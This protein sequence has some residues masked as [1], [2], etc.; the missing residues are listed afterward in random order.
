MESAKFRIFIRLI[1][2]FWITLGFLSAF[3]SSTT[4][5]KAHEETVSRLSPQVES[6]DRNELFELAKAYSNL[7]AS[8]SAIKVYTAALSSNKND[9]EAKTLIGAEQMR[10][11][12]EKVA[13][14]TLKEVIDS[15]KKFT[16]AY[17]VL[18]RIYEKRNNKYELRLLYQDLLKHDG[19][20]AEYLLK[21]CELTTLDS[22]YDLSRQYCTR[23]GQ[24]DK[25]SP[26]PA[27]YLGLTAKD[28]G[29][30]A[31]AEKQLKA[32]A[33][34]FP[35]SVLAQM[36]YAEHL[37]SQKNFITSYSYFKAARQLEPK[38]SQALLGL[39]N[40]AFEIQKY[41]EALQIFFE[42]CRSDRAVMPHFRRATNTL[43]T[44]RLN[45]WLRKYEQK[46]EKCGG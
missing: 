29:D 40:S 2:S 26:I 9:L 33:E 41:E 24:L 16:A 32:A 36:S 8:E 18:G 1:V 39:A 10:M 12:Q 21:L 37:V 34:R 7:G 44:N 42:N 31:S 17:R 14:Q 30:S 27:V 35:D 25:S 13:I 6:L 46:V 23:A 11:G 3:A 22:Y 38:N 19:E 28:T 4:D 43:R 20:K 5:K 45:S 15:N